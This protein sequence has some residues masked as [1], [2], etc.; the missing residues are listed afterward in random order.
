MWK[1]VDSQFNRQWYKDLI[2]QTFEKP[3]AYCQVVEEGEKAKDN[4]HLDLTDEEVR[5]THEALLF[6]WHNQPDHPAGDVLDGVVT[7]LRQA[8]L[9]S[10][11]VRYCEE[12]GETFEEV[13][14]LPSSDG[15]NMHLCKHHFI[16]QTRHRRQFS[17]CS[18]APEW[19]DAAIV[20]D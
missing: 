8:A 19:E 14:K 9:N 12:C 1:V 20:E 2:G 11:P 18:P 6:L 10:C 4:N 3:P 5:A 16:K 17:E 15:D 7:K 13:R